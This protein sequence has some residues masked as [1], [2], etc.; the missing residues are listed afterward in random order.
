MI[1]PAVV[2]IRGTLS[3]RYPLSRPRIRQRCRCGAAGPGLPAP[4]G[5]RR[6]LEVFLLI[7]KHLPNYQ[8]NEV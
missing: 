5:G 6:E 8:Q 7:L 4:A 2:A 1:R 3:H